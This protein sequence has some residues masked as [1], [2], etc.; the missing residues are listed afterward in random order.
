M[1]NVETLYTQRQYIHHTA[2]LQFITAPMVAVVILQSKV[3]MVT[4]M[5]TFKE[6]V[7][8]GE[9]NQK[10]WDGIVNRYHHQLRSPVMKN[11]KRCFSPE[12]LSTPDGMATIVF[13][14][15]ERITSDIIHEFLMVLYHDESII[16]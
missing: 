1:I 5:K 15:C 4:K 9:W 2:L 10:R 3:L 6:L 14:A 16:V 13:S 12:S 11:V 7:D 8:L